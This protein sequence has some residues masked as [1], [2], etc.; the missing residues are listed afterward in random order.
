MQE[1][2]ARKN[3]QS[4]LTNYVDQLSVIYKSNDYD[5]TTTTRDRVAEALRLIQIEMC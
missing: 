5:C 3:Y 1:N 4:L 2:E